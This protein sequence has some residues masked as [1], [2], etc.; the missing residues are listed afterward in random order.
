MAE[1]H[2]GRERRSVQA[3]EE[4]A[5]VLPKISPIRAQS[6]DFA[7]TSSRGSLPKL[8]R[9]SRGKQKFFIAVPPASEWVLQAKRREAERRALMKEKAGEFG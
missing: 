4:L 7:E 9:K 1:E 5:R 2:P 6:I 3:P 8:A